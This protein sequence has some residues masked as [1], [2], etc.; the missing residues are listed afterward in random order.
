MDTSG[1][2]DNLKKHE[3]TLITA[4]EEEVVRL[5]NDNK[6]LREELAEKDRTHKATV[7]ELQW[8]L[9]HVI[10]EKVQGVEDKLKRVEQELAV[11]NK[12][13]EMTKKLLDINSDIL[14]VKDIVNKLVNKLPEIKFTVTPV[15]A[16]QQ[17]GGDKGQNQNKGNQNQGGG[18]KDQNKGGDK[19]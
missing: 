14:D 6:D 11:A 1:S 15:I 18:N 16:G 10:D 17:G 13:V 8:K 7:S 19:E 12:E 4:L 2:F 5:E 3:A 9:S